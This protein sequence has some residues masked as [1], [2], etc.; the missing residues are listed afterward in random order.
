MGVAAAY[1]EH[2][3]CEEAMGPRMT[4]APRIRVRVPHGPWT[5]AYAGV[6]ICF[7]LR[8]MDRRASQARLAMTGLGVRR[9][10]ADVAARGAEEWRGW[11]G[12][13]EP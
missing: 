3:H 13:A 1:N 6:T 8:S 2:R 10:K 11:P 7:G 4:P 12:T 5:P 9:A